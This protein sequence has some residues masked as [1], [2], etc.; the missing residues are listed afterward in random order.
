MKLVALALGSL[1]LLTSVALP[2]AERVII[3]E[4]LAINAAG[5]PDEDGDRSDWIELHN[6][7]N[8]PVRLAGWAL[9]DGA[10]DSKR[11]I[12]PAVD[13]AAGGYLV[14]YASDKNRAV[15]GKPLHTDFKLQGKGDYLGLLRPDGSIADEFAPTYP[16]QTADVSYG[17]IAGGGTG[18]LLAPTPGGPNGDARL[19]KVAAVKLSHKRGIHDQPFKLELSTATEGAEV[20]YTLDGT[21]PTQQQGR[22]YR[23]P[24]EI[25]ATTVL[26]VAAFKDGFSPADTKT[27][28][29]LFPTDIIRQSAD[30]LP[31]SGWPYSWGANR[32]DYGMDPAVVNDPRFRAEIIPALKAIPSFSIVM[33]LDDL[34]GAKDGIYSNPGRDGRETEKPASVEYL[35]TGRDEGFQIDAGIRIRGGFSRM[36]MNPKHAFRLFFRKEYGDAKLKF[37]LYGPDG[38]QEFDNLDLRT[39]QN[40]S[41]SFQA[42]PRGI[43]VRDQ[44][45]RD[46][47]LATGQPAARGDFCHLYING[48]YWGLYNTCERPEASYGATYFGGDE[49]DYDVIKVNSGFGEQG[50]NSF[51]TITTDGTIDAWK[52]LND[53]ARQGLADDA[54]YQRL[55]GR[56]P[57]GS[58]NSSFP[59]L[60]DPDNLIDYMLVIFYGG[61]LD[62]PITKF[63]G[64][65]MPNNWYGIRNRNGEHGFR[66]FIWDAEHTFLDL[67]ED[68]TGPFPAGNNLETSN[69][70]WL[71]Q[72]CLDNAEF[73]VLVADH[74]HRHF[75]NGGLLTASTIAEKFK[76][77]SA[78]IESAVI[79]ESARW[80]DL[81]AGF[82]MGAPPRLNAQ[83]ELLKGPL[84]RDDDWRSEVAR[85]LTD[86]IPKRS[87]VVLA[88]LFSQGLVADVP[89]PLVNFEGT[90]AVP[91]ASTGD[92][93]FTL[94]G[95]DPRQLG[96]AISPAARKADGG[97]ELPAGRRLRARTRLAGDWSAL[98]E[99]AGR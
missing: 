33:D 5:S 95:S 77:R 82:P 35:P 22:V 19:G 75:F 86:Y 31:P 49:K 4:I 69:P 44:F 52:E 3:S 56:N 17:L 62:A 9:V 55:L 70:Q 96:G 51:G 81:E 54:R 16:N 92:V 14:V 63:G 78:Q 32:V 30:G 26:R 47:Q 68:R 61:N 1:G 34:F 7:G 28:T 76:R 71:W 85:L 42:D 18:F 45:N 87:D 79:G 59:V 66:F 12:I 89:A 57:D 29:F 65:S 58:R 48:V 83:G 38:A 60:L 74:I 84:N 39:F 67:P 99:V 88:Q 98:T 64:N 36:P 21:A 6:P 20:R 11:W 27:H 90:R 72:Q 10:K 37:P 24:L 25:N 50:M 53:L 8:T 2:A 91:G 13:L 15:P 23:S 46:L 94:D 40:Y 97:V 80:G 41:W 73:R 43:F 93:Y